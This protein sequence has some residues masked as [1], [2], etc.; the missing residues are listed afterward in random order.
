MLPELI[1]NPPNKIDMICFIGIDQHVIQVDDHKKSNFSTRIL[2][3][4]F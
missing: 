3:I 4:Y 2:L 1:K